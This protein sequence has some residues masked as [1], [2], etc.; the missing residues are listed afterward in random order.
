MATTKEIV[1]DNVALVDGAA[2]NDPIVIRRWQRAVQ[3]AVNAIWND[4]PWHFK[5]AENVLFEYIPKWLDR[6]NPGSDNPL[7]DDYGSLEADGSG[8]YQISPRRPITPRPIGEINGL[9]HG[10]QVAT[11]SLGPIT[12]YGVS[13]STESG[14]C[15]QF[16]PE[17]PSTTNVLLVYMRRA[18]RCIYEPDGDSPDEIGWVPSQ[19]HDLISDG[20][21]WFNAHD[22][23][24]SQESAEQALV[25]LGL[26][27]MRD[28]ET[29]GSQG[30][31]RVVGYRPGRRGVR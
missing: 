15:L 18:P 13:A 7:P 6:Q 26:D 24:S 10:S 22:V 1:D 31:N 3:R 21:R 5:V 17:L 30:M 9:I 2:S 25:K 12:R 16:Y 19:W 11:M 14:P 4:R 29:W 20:A 27:Q 8:V 23:A 28:R